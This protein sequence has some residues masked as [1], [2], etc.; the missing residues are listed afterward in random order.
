MRGINHGNVPLVRGSGSKLSHLRM[1]FLFFEY[2]LYLFSL[3]I[4]SNYVGVSADPWKRLSQHL[5]NNTD[6]FTGKFKDWILVAVF[7]V[8]TIKGEAI[9]IEKFIKQQKSRKLIEKILDPNFLGT[10]V[11]A[12]LVRVPHARD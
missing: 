3:L 10:G 12:Q 4:G 5:N 2:V 6:K 9:R 1:A 11:L 8:S 7:E